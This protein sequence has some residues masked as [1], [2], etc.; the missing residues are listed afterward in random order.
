M[1]GFS[2]LTADACNVAIE[3]ETQHVVECREI[4]Q[5]SLG[6]FTAFWLDSGYAWCWNG[7]YPFNAFGCRDIAQ[8]GLGEILEPAQSI[9][10]HSAVP[11]EGKGWSTV[12]RSEDLA[13]VRRSRVGSRLWARLE[14]ATSAKRKISAKLKKSG[15]PE[16]LEGRQYRDRARSPG[17]SRISDWPLRVG[18][19]PSIARR[20]SNRPRDR[21]ASRAS[22]MF[23]SCSGD[24][25][26][27]PDSASGCP[28]GGR[29]ELR[30]RT[31]G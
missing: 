27:I 25:S 21:R 20:R 3:S 13:T 14:H 29:K 18:G 8:N 12:R 11:L 28:A 30:C 10:R 22:L 26:V 17:S 24:S 7:R 31:F 23:S 16:A 2:S 9:L 1:P 4:V 19:K 15:R 6:E 5:S